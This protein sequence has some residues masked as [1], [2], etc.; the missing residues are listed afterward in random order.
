MALVILGIGAGLALAELWLRY[1][2]IASQRGIVPRVS[3][4]RFETQPGLLAPGRY[5]RGRGHLPKERISIN[6]L[7]F[8][9]PA[10][11]R[12]KAPGVVRIL[13]VGDS[14][15][16]GLNV[17]DSETLPARLHR[18]LQRRCNTPIEVVNAGVSGST[19]T[20]QRELIRRALPLQP[21]LVVLNFFPN[22][23]GDLIGGNSHWSWME[24]ERARDAT[25]WGR[26]RIHL[27]RAHV[28][29]FLADAKQRIATRLRAATT[30]ENSS[31]KTLEGVLRDRYL[32]GLRSLD[33]EL[34]RKQIPLIF[35]SLPDHPGR[36]TRL[37][38]ERIQWF[39]G[40]AGSL[41][42]PVV[43]LTPALRPP[44]P[45]YYLLPSDGHPS[46]L[47]YER[48]AGHLAAAIPSLPPLDR[49][50]DAGATSLTAEAS[51]E[52]AE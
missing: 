42:R 9:G 39:V 41:N 48:A 12:D 45:E 7:G 19:I 47:A 46:A 38:E 28:W 27:R 18:E 43:D 37:H 33:E 3:A 13:V 4:S 34:R 10:I 25:V 51:L 5:T 22:D 2:P 15:V 32:A 14:V 16:F 1:S 49:W 17:N 29:R 26:I 21:D 31:D 44:L 6:S 11:R 35:S 40:A 36:E 20:G 52:Y 8:R 23:I 24:R 50:C 30:L